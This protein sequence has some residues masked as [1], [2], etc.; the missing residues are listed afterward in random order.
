MNLVVLT[1]ALV[2]LTSTSAYHHRSFKDF[3]S[4]VDGDQEN[5][6]CKDFV[7]NSYDH[8][9]LN[10]HE[11]SMSTADLVQFH[12]CTMRKFPKVF[13]KKFHWVVN[14]RINNCKLRNITMPDALVDNLEN[15]ERIVEMSF[16]K[17]H[18]ETFPKNYF[19]FFGNLAKLDVSY[20]AIK[21]IDGH[22]FDQALS[23]KMLYLEGNIIS[24]ISADAFTN[25]KNLT[26]LVLSGN[27]IKSLPA[28]VFHSN[29]LLQVIDLSDN[30]LTFLPVNIFTGLPHLD[31]LRLDKN[32]FATQ[33]FSPD[34]LN[35]PLLTFLNLSSTDL[36]INDEMFS[37]CPNLEV[38]DLSRNNLKKIDAHLFKNLS[39]LME[40]S[41]HD[42]SLSEFDYKNEVFKKENFVLEIY[43]NSW[44]CSYL[45][46]MMIYFD[47]KKIEHYPPKDRFVD[48]L[49]YSCL[50]GIKCLGEFSYDK[51]SDFIEGDVS[52][53]LAEKVSAAEGAFIVT[54]IFLTIFAVIAIAVIVVLVLQPDYILGRFRTRP[55]SYRGN[56]FENNSEILSGD[57]FAAP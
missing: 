17:N 42:N 14:L 33:T 47:G 21:A 51:Y 25:N 56:S 24:E 26:S 50:R 23:L 10:L 19:T 57:Q 53:K 6:M 48:I 29:E 4:M 30:E 11:Q 3:C 39:N 18:I 46:N 34:F 5:F 45:K 12:N 22:L 38:I 1:L 15:T 44:K 55:N 40:L 52:A 7:F 35:I 41:I 31:L 32:D 37:K 54:I 8:V 28:T 49:E 43:E 36:K 27:K 2:V 13:F 9:E 20:N 16:R